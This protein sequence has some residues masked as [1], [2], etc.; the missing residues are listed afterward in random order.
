MGENLLNFKKKN[1]F[2]ILHLSLKYKRKKKKKLFTQFSNQ[3]K[4]KK[5]SFLSKSYI[6]FYL[7]KV[8]RLNIHA[9]LFK[10][11]IRNPFPLSRVQD[12]LSQQVLSYYRICVLCFITQKSFLLKGFN[13]T[14]NKREFKTQYTDYPYMNI[15]QHSKYSKNKSHTKRK[16]IVMV[17]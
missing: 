12:S 2:V 5:K 14:D 3:L 10:P 16:T 4:G 9:S 6:T 15:T 8:K 11:K 17:Y 7:Q 1:L 13:N